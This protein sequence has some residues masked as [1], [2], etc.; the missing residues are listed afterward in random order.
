MAA[1]RV[2]QRTNAPPVCQSCIPFALRDCPMPLNDVTLWS[3]G[4]TES[5]GVLADLYEPDILKRPILQH[6]NVFV[7]WDA[8]KHHAD[9]LATSQVVH[10]RDL[11]QHDLPGPAPEA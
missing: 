4:W 7:P 10:L 3:V 2:D 1:A 9:T 8:F 5:A 6:H 11:R